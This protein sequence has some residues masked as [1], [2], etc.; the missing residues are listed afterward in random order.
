[1]AALHPIRARAFTGPTAFPDNEPNTEFG[2]AVG[3]GAGFDIPGTGITFNI[4]GVWADGAPGY[5]TDRGQ[6]GALSDGFVVGVFD[7]SLTSPTFGTLIATDIAT[8]EA[9][10]VKAGIGGDLAPD[11][12]FNLQASYAE[13]DL[14]ESLGRPFVDQA[15]EVAFA[16]GPAALQVGVFDPALGVVVGGPVYSGDFNVFTASGW[17]GWAPVSGFIA[18]VELAYEKHEF[19]IGLETDRWGGV[20]RVQKSF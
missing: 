20:F 3:G 16:A 2:W 10:S 8:T 12:V 9:W 18:A 17:I 7:T 13:V 11:W 14:P 19:D 6:V 15:G 1:M 4:Q 5:A